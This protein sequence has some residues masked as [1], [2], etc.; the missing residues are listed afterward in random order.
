MNRFPSSGMIALMAPAPLYDL[1]S[2]VGPEMDLSMLS[3]LDQAGLSY[4]TVEG[5]PLLRARIAELSGVAPD[6]VLVT[7][8]GMH[9][10]F[11]LA[12][13]VCRQATE[14]V[15]T[16]PVFPPFRD[17]L[18]ALEARVVEH[19]LSF[20]QGYTLDVAGL[21]TRLSA[22]T[23]LV[24]L[25]SP[26]N[27]SGVGHTV[28]ELEE[29]LRLMEEICPNAY[30]LVDETYREGFYGDEAASCGAT[31]ANRVVTVASL[32]KCHGAP[33]LRLG[34]IITKDR[35]LYSQLALGK[36]NTVLSCSSLDEALGLQLLTDHQAILAER[37]P[38]LRTGLSA[39]ARW[40]EKNED[41][42]EW[43][44]PSAGTVCCVRLRPEVFDQC[45]VNRFYASLSDKSI[46]LAPG[47]WFGEE[48]RVFRLGFA[49]MPYELFE[50]G[51]DALEEAILSAASIADRQRGAYGRCD[52]CKCK[53]GCAAAK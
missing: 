43:V 6:D 23:K 46:R 36:F 13:A 19:R 45:A 52:R 15:L 34:W 10:L 53:S 24:C 40:I 37:R 18:T 8:G 11:L 20:D 47:G 51:L 3:S 50:K 38:V 5:E 31:I 17:V 9:S 25:A 27:P 32:S 16:T 42:V 28:A 49:A 21:R 39:I 26:Q 4:G 29:V 35:E 22:D 14:V 33:G 30:L 48:D 41:Y 1:S 7:V 2:S 12:F 44:K